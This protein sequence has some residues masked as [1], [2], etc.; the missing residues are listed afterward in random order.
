MILVIAYE[1]ALATSIAAKMPEAS[2]I[3]VDGANSE[4]ICRSRQAICSWRRTGLFFT[5]EKAEP[6]RPVSFFHK[7]AENSASLNL[8]LRR[9]H[10]PGFGLWRWR[11]RCRQILALHGIHQLAVFRPAIGAQLS[12]TRGHVSWVTISFVPRPAMRSGELQIPASSS[13]SLADVHRGC[14]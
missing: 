14:H 5:L 1:G 9:R 7:T 4:A 2:S 11:R 3:P 10:V 12:A 13:D 8:R 6:I